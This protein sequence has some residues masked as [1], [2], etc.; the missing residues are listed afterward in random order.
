MRNASIDVAAAERH[1]VIVCGT[2][3][4]AGSTA[5]LTWALILALVRNI[6]A[7]VADFRSGADWQ[8]RMS[9]DLVGKRLGLVG[10]GRLGTRVA[11][12]GID[13]E[14]DVV[15]WSPNLTDERA[16]EAGVTRIATLDE[17][18]A[19]R[20]HRLDPRAAQRRH[21]RADRRRASSP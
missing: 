1:G 5:Q 12:V 18:L 20:G 6:P 11:H 16:A 10:L 15:A 4:V 17:L 3:G 9:I 21:A 13:F 7:E 19:H 2:H 14:M 8:R